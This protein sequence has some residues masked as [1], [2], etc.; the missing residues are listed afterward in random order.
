M[1][2]IITIT[3]VIRM[4]MK[5]M[6]HTTI[7]QVSPYSALRQAAFHVHSVVTIIPGTVTT[8]HV[9]LE[10]LVVRP[11]CQIFSLRP[12]QYGSMNLSTFGI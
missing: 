4:G 2:A 3:S 5:R 8:R 9:S 6:S 1:R 7:K 12:M 10:W 11:L